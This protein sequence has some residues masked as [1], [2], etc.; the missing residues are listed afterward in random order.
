MKTTRCRN[1]ALDCTGQAGPFETKVALVNC[2]G[3]RDHWR[4]LRRISE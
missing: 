3:K 2:W 4:V 1:F